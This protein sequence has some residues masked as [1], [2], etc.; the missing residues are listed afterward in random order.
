MQSM[1][2]G[3]R[4]GALDTKLSLPAR[5]LGAYFGEEDFP[6]ALAPSF[7]PRASDPPI[8]IRHMGIVST[9]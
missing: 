7:K 1:R 4:L 8:D 9:T 2:L 5:A 6:T 3:G